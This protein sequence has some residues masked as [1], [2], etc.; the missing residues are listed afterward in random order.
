[1]RSKRF[2]LLFWCAAA[3]LVAYVL[4][5]FYASQRAPLF[6]RFERQWAEDVKELETSGKLPKAWG[7]IKEIKIIGGTP[8]TKDWLKRIQ[9]PLKANPEGHHTLEVLIVAWEENGK[10]GVLVQYNIEDGKTKNTL[11]E[12]GRTLILSTVAGEKP[13]LSLI[14]GFKR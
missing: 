2:S 13:L 11:M 5:D 1:M 8:E 6:K 3:A 14:E 7:D 12:V 9:V 4:L 10:R